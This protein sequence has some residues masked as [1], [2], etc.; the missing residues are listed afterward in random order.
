MNNSNR[1]SRL[2]NDYLTY[3]RSIGYQLTADEK[4]LKDF[5]RYTISEE[6]EGPLTKEIV[7]KWCESGGNLSSIA[8]G[9][10]YEI[11]QSFSRY[12][13]A[14]DPDTEPLP[15]RPYGN[16]H[17]RKRPHI[18]TLEETCSL[19]KQCD[20]LSPPGG[21]RGITVKYVIGLLWVTGLRT[22]ELISLTV[23]DVDLENGIIIVRHSKFSKDRY[24]PITE[25]TVWHLK[26][27]RKTVVRKLGNVP[28]AKSFFIT[29]D[30][31]SLN[32]R[33]LEYDFSLIRDV[34][35]PG[36][37]DYKHVRLYDFRHTLA[38]RTIQK[39][40]E[41]GEDPYEKLFLLSTFMGHVHPEDTYWYISSTPE[42]LDLA[43]QQYAKMFGGNHY[44]QK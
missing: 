20:S 40:M 5:A 4:Y 17:K 9:R 18:Y 1:I 36:D 13:G 35:D 42:L 28:T 19:I 24:V 10:R 44:E 26:E 12:A 11:I 22:S 34:V 25:D 7:F 23:D 30:G 14:F 21:L 41:A 38:T 39:W 31:R 37:S 32:V 6:Y 2:I 8:K 33:S 43:V 27:Y 3:K 15:S 16:P 29:T